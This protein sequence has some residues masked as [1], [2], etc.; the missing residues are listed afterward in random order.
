[1]TTK[2]ESFE[3][4]SSESKELL[5]DLLIA[6]NISKSIREKNGGMIPILSDVSLTIRD[7]KDK[8]QI[9]S[10]LGPSGSGKT[11]LLR[12]L[13]CLDQPDRG[14]IHCLTESEGM[15][16]TRAGRRWNG[17]PKLPAF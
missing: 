13:A 12:I 2:T 11:S 10:I 5:A 8:P 15:R 14:K 1:M 6:R 4:P 17:F 16:P 9:L 7:I 3:A